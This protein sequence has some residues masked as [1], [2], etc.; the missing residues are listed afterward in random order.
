MEEEGDLSVSIR[1]LVSRGGGINAV[2]MIVSLFLVYPIC[3]H[4]FQ[5][6]AGSPQEMLEGINFRIRLREMSMLPFK[7]I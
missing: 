5:L 2:K 7:E 4:S 6:Q 3:C 1:E